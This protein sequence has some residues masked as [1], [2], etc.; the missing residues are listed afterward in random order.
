VVGSSKE[1]KNELIVKEKTTELVVKDKTTE[2]IVKEKATL[3]LGSKEKTTLKLT[4]KVNHMLPTPLCFNTE[5]K[6]E[7]F[8]LA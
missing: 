5:I 8:M 4:A 6:T 1:K 2:L 7:L 3:D